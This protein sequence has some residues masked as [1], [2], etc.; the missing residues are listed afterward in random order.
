M[1]QVKAKAHNHLLVA[2]KNLFDAD[3][4]DVFPVML[5]VGRRRRL[6]DEVVADDA[7][8][9]STDRRDLLPTGTSRLHWVNLLVIVVMML[10]FLNNGIW[11]A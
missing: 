7:G 5:F 4:V 6:V 10:I 2:L 8:I 9:R 1:A 11:L 3:A